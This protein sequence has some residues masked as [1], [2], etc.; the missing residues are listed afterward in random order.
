MVS[1]QKEKSKKRVSFSD[2]VVFVGLLLFGLLA[3]VPFVKN[4]DLVAYDGTYY[5]N[6][7]KSFIGQSAATGS[8]P[9]GYPALIAFFLPIARDGVRAAQ[10]VSLLSG[11]GSVWI[12][13]ILAR[14]HV[15]RAHAFLAALLLAATP[16]Y[17]RLTMMTLSE[18]VFIFWLLLGLWFYDCGKYVRFSLV[19]GLAAITRPEA[20]GVFVI[21]A[22]LRRRPVKRLA[23]MA[24]SFLVVYSVNLVALSVTLDRLVL[25]PKTEFFGTGAS[26]WK[27]REAWG[28]FSGREELE[29]SLEAT[30]KTAVDLLVDSIQRLPGEMGLLGRHVMPVAF[31]LALFG[32]FR[33]RFYILACF[34]PLVLYPIFTVR[35][36]A[37]Y[38][39]PYVPFL[40]FYA[41]V[42]LK[43][44]KSAHIRDVAAGAL[45]ISAIAGAIVNLNQ[46]K[47][48]VSEGF[49]WAKQAGA[50]W[51]DRI[52]I[53]DVVADRKPF[54]AF[55]AGAK[56]LEIPVA[57]YN[58]ALRR[59]SDQGVDYLS[60]HKETI[61]IF[62]PALKPLLYDKAAINGEIRFEQVDERGGVHLLYKRGRPGD[63]LERKRITAP[64]QGLIVM[65]AWSP[66]GAHI[67]YREAGTQSGGKIWISDRTGKQTRV[68]VDEPATRDP[69]SWAPDSRRIAFA[70]NSTGDMN[71][72]ILDISTGESVQLTTD[73]GMDRSPSWSADGREVYFSSNR[74]GQDDIWSIGVETGKLVRI[75]KEGGCLF[76]AASPTGQNV[77]W[78]VPGEGV[79]VREIES[80]RT[81]VFDDPREVRFAPAWSP[82]G[83]FIA[84]TA[85]DW[86]GSDVYLIRV[87]NGS[88]LLL[89]KY[90]S[91]D[92]MPSW[93]TTNNE[94]L[95]VTNEDDDYGI[96]MLSGVESYFERLG[97]PGVIRTLPA[98]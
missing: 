44:I 31:L 86:G 87:R 25:V 7:A 74:S 94:M 20:L 46:L 37:R 89:T 24:A 35:T 5:I 18:S 14:R 98:D 39:L 23:M 43:E 63:G 72:H 54:F 8:F 78:I 62:R 19:M 93:G 27:G 12:L 90:A 84:V 38:I 48:P 26:N 61:D 53:D 36:E 30:E 42:G 3:R 70:N 6:Q 67:V 55:Y 11:I 96:W 83:E 88:S 65:P 75:T 40:L 51:R 77:A 41:V 13:Y 9:I 29:E 64:G 15:T 45:V 73:P 58:D 22:L 50:E 85:T 68:L 52:Q 57:P 34:L 81:V 33:R 95:I 97:A 69:I 21:L 76:P 2:P 91:G 1:K 56:Y 59:L 66:D 79:A 32:I 71:I 80:G 49:A 10:I 92:G 47:I 16:L 60:L 82:D 28:D 4:F 17:I